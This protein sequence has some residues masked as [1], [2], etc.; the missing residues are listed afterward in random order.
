MDA[1]SKR[2]KR[3]KLI[4]EYGYYC[5]WCGKSLTEDAITIEHLY[6]KSRGG[7]NSLENLR[8]ACKPCNQSR[9]NS[10]FP[11]GWTTKR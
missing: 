9:G 4:A 7:S 1:K 8:L 5:F 2:S 11:P 3:Q 10:L 6:P